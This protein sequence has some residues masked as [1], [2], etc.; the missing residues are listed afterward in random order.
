MLRLVSGA[1]EEQDQPSCLVCG[2]PTY[3]PEKSERPWARGVAG[4]RLVLIC[5][6]CQSD[7]AAWIERLDRCGNCG[8]TRL[9][10][11]LDRL[12]CRECGH[13]AGKFQWP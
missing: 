8:S 7:S 5:P 13:T 6:R 11:T 12:I 9:N 2:R 3:D 10:V 1:V 4:G